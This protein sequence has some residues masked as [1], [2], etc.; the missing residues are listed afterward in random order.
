MKQ[1]SRKNLSAAG[2]YFVLALGWAWLCWVPAAL[3]GLSSGRTPLVAALHYLGGVSPL[4]AALILLRLEPTAERADFWRR[5]VDTRRI[6]PFWWTVTL[7]TIPALTALAAL[8]DRVL[9]GAG[10]QL[11]AAADLAENPLAALPSALLLA[12]FLLIFGPLPEEIGWRGYALDRLQRGR[13]ENGLGMDALRASLMIGTFW[14]LWHLPLYFI[15]DTFQHNVGVFTTRYWLIT[16]GLFPTSVLMTWI[17][18]ATQRST[19][20]AVLFHF[21]G[22][23]IGE[24]FELSPRAE[25]FL[26]SITLLAALGVI[27]AWQARLA[28]RRSRRSP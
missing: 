24:L 9:G 14:A 27:V 18:N 21:M 26:L 8:L 23:W 1:G 22:N 10:A 5:L 19:L 15:A 12:L 11:E 17:F 4:A 7:L 6:A 13:A 2:K 16:L 20:T 28:P 3:I 25:V